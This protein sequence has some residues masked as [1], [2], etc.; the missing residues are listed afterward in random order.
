MADDDSWLYGEDGGEGEEDKDKDKDEAADGVTEQVGDTG[1]ELTEDQMEVGDQIP[2]ETAEEEEA[3]ASGSDD[4]EDDGIQVTIDKDKLEAAKT[5]YQTMQLK[6]NSVI[7]LGFVPSHKE[8]K[9]KF[10]VE[11]SDPPT[12]TTFLTKHV[13]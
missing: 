13:L 10:A 9:G 2:E 5:T 1:E 4:S 11:V 12:C 3:N 7:D 8:K 6:K